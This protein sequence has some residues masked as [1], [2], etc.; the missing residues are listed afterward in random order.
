MTRKNRPDVDVYF[1]IIQPHPTLR[2]CE[3][4]TVI[5]HRKVPAECFLKGLADKRHT[6]VVN[7]IGGGR[8]MSEVIRNVSFTADLWVLTQMRYARQRQSRTHRH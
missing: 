4:E 7:G 2:F 1:T 6:V 8:P 5:A 3:L